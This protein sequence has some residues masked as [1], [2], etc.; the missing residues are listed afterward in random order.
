MRTERLGEVV[1][2]NSID[3]SFEVTVEVIREESTVHESSHHLS[4]GSSKERP[5]VV[6]EN[7]NESP[8]ARSWEI[9]AKTT[10][11][12]WRKAEID[13]AVG[14]TDDCHGVTVVTGDWPETSVLVLLGDCTN[15]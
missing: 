5:Q 11:S 6:L 4:P 1:L 2:A 8:E 7:W 15:P 13:A 14:G 9:R 3:E 12:D 10:T